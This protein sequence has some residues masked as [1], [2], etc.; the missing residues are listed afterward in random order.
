MRSSWRW[1]G[2]SDPMPL[3]RVGQTGAVMLET[4]LSDLPA[5]AAWTD[6][7]IAERRQMVEAHR[8]AEGQ[9]LRWEVLGGIPIH[10]DIKLGR[11]DAR[12]YI[13]TMQENVRRLCGQGVR[14]ILINAMPLI[15]WART[16]LTRPLPTGAETVAYDALDVT[17]FDLFLIRR[18][19]AETD[20]SPRVLAAAKD[21]Y[22]TMDDARRTE[23]KSM[24]TTSLP[25][26]DSR[27]DRSAFDALLAD[28]NRL[29]RAEYRAHLYDFIGAVCDV[30]ETEGGL[31]G[32]HPDDP[33]WQICGLP[34]IMSCLEDYQ[35]LFDAVPSATNGILFCSGALGAS[36]KNDLVKIASVLRGRVHYAHLR[37]VEH[38]EY[39]A[40]AGWSFQEAEHLSD[41]ADLFAL[42]R[43]LVDEEHARRGAGEGA[44]RC[45]IP[46]RAD[47][48]QH[49]LG[50]LDVQD[51]N[52]GYAPIGMTKATAE[53][54][55]ML[56]AIERMRG[57]A[58]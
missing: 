12:R 26:G 41:K 7:L 20:Y 13:G 21:R 48:G 4:S 33:P 14:R 31:L 56:H 15:D 50:D 54:R 55:G 53:L 38:L 46:F 27:H 1:F 25:G 49:I 3:S 42:A 8:N 34:K 28:Y 57:D 29:G 52:P 24:L 44:L 45:D 39:H 32:V 47:H 22:D 9:T 16:E 30:L 58:A 6:A 2:P 23:L 40:E 36:P 18:V 19:G 43:L 5:G 51:G 10:D 37:A 35:S 11:G 17:V